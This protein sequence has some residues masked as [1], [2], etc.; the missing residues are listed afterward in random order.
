MTVT[1]TLSDVLA[2]VKVNGVTVA[3]GSSSSAIA[4]SVGSN[5][6][7]TVVTA[8]NGTTT[9]TYTITV[10]R[11]AEQCQLVEPRTK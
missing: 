1:P 5:V 3:S 9:K 10:T 6:I 4:L 8:Q 7:T 11:A 2:S